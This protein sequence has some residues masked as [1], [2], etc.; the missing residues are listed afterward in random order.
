MSAAL[1]AA[2]AAWWW[3]PPQVDG[4][5]RRLF[6]ADEPRAAVDAVLAATVL[7]PVAAVLLLGPV[8]GLLAAAVVTPAARSAVAGMETVASRRRAA[9][10]ASQ[11][12]T[13]L[14]L[15]VA[16]L[17][18]GRPPV[19]AFAAV[20]DVTDPP[21]GD[22]LAAV[23]SRLAVAGDPQSVWTHLAQQPVLAPLGRAFRR[24]DASGT[25]VSRVVGS[26]ADELRRERR[27]ALREQSRRV[28][29]RTAAPLG[30]CFLP[31]FL[32]VGVV[33][34]VIGVVGTLRLG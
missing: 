5:C 21:L 9:E 23:A 25:P 16:A 26:V 13:A 20:A 19:A 32:L 18:V 11:L 1:L 17:D 7:V 29:V 28:G 33:P 31:A 24:A 12:P 4:R 2:L 3:V 27:A 10:I 34:T 15:V 6:V 22:E 8:I 30:A 14:D